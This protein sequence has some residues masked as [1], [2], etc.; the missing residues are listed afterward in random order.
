MWAIIYVN[1]LSKPYVNVPTQ[2]ADGA[3]VFASDCASCHG[4][5][6]SGGVGRPLN[7][8]EVLKTFPNIADQLEFV[9]LGD[10]GTGIGH[11]YGKPRTGR[12]ASTSP[13]AT[14]AT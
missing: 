1:T 4:A 14:T 10:A 9:W 7:N 5:T 8:G 6:A 11:P 12:A 3:T 13:A 2:L